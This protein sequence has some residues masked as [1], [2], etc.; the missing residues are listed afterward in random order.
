MLKALTGTLL[1]VVSVSVLILTLPSAKASDSV[2]DTVTIAVPVSCSMTSDI[3]TDHTAEVNNG[4]TVGEIGTTNITA[5]CNDNS[6]YAIYAIGYTDNTYGKTVLTGAALSSSADIATSSTVTTG[7]SS[8]AMKLTSISGTYAP[9]I[10]SDFASYQAVPEEYTKVAYR[11]SSTDVGINAVGSNFSTTYRAYISPTQPAGTYVGQVK[12]TLVHPN[13]DFPMPSNL[14][15]TTLRLNEQIDVGSLATAFSNERI[16][17]DF[18]VKITPADL[19]AHLE[20]PS[21]GITTWSQFIDSLP[22]FLASAGA[23]NIQSDM[24]VI[25]KDQS[26]SYLDYYEFS[27]YDINNGTDNSPEYWVYYNSIGYGED[28]SNWLYMPATTGSISF[29]FGDDSYSYNSFRGLIGEFANGAWLGEQ[30][31]GDYWSEGFFRTISIYGGDDV[32]NPALI[33]WLNDNATLLYIEDSPASKEWTFNEF[34]PSDPDMEWD[35]NGSIYSNI[36]TAYHFDSVIAST[37]Y[38]VPY[39]TFYYHDATEPYTAGDGFIYLPEGAVI[40]E[41]NIDYPIGWGFGNINNPTQFSQ[42]S[43]PTITLQGGEDLYNPAFISWLRENAT[44]N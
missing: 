20:I 28:T 34:A 5:F 29:T 6:G 11:D 40:P 41:Y 31:Y 3:V 1:S 18:V 30:Y 43:P 33:Q 38:G 24:E 9:T 22:S 25:D 44:S 2:V 7:T 13:G 26:F 21:T 27:Y 32:T 37:A 14:V 12:Y 35:V 19:C 39:W 17:L 15:G 4:Q 16:D 23:I 8:W 36:Y 10:V 42:V